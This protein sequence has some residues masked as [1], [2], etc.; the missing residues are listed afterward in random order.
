M[1]N[2]I[3]KLRGTKI[4]DDEYKI[5]ILT[6]PLFLIA[7]AD[8]T[9]DPEEK[10]FMKNILYNFLNPLYNENI[11]HE[12]YE[13]LID[14]YILDFEELFRSNNHKVEILTEFS[15]FDKEVKNAILELLNE[16]ANISDGISEQEK[17]EISNVQDYI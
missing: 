2:T 6:Y 7:I 1:K 16:V 17:L 13:S 4:S 9:F 11:T 3:E 14:N 5:F 8:G 15:K 10:D 12:Q